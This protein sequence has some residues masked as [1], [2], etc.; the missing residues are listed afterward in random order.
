MPSLSGANIAWNISLLSQVSVLY[1]NDLLLFLYFPV[2]REGLERKGHA[3]S[4]V[5][6]PSTSRGPGISCGLG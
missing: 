1:Q 3:L 4:G 5:L 2:G 6:A